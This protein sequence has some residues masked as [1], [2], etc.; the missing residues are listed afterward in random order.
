MGVSITPD[1]HDHDC[2]PQMASSIDNEDSVMTGPARN[3]TTNLQLC[4]NLLREDMDRLQQEMEEHNMSRSSH[5][6]TK[7][8][9]EAVYSST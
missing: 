4:L 5:N 8:D 9:T 6:G 1:D 2:V 3:I 7:D